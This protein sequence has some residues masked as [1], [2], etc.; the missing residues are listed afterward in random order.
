MTSTASPPYLKTEFLQPLKSSFTRFQHSQVWFKALTTTIP[1]INSSLFLF[2]LGFGEE[3][4]WCWWPFGG[5]Q[6]DVQF[7][8]MF[9]SVMDIL[10]FRR[11]D[12]TCELKNDNCGVSLNA[13]VAPKSDSAFDELSELFCS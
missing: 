3:W 1:S 6:R 2:D 8:S 5:S 10:F 7:F 13:I 12:C 4:E 9:H 11:V